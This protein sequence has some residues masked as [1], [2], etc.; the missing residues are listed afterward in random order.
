MSKVFTQFKGSKKIAPAS[1][2]SVVDNLK[3]LNVTLRRESTRILNLQHFHYEVYSGWSDRIT[4]IR[5]I[6][7]NPSN[8][9]EK[10]QKNLKALHEI[11]EV[12]SE[13]HFIKSDSLSQIYISLL[14]KIKETDVMIL[15]AK[16]VND[17]IYPDLS[18]D[19]SLK[20]REV[21]QILHQA[22]AFIE[23]RQNSNKG[24]GVIS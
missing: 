6:M 12:N 8:S 2:N 16:N 15:Q 1:E 7:D 13:N 3:A 17:L 5:K 10:D 21:R 18:K 24:L 22:E 20:T 4:E 19:I 23:I 11:A 14:E 9:G